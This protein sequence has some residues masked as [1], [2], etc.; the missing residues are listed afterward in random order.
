MGWGTNIPQV[1]TGQTRYIRLRLR[2]IAPV[3]P[4]GVGDIWTRQVHHPR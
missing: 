4:S 2:I 1:Q 3:N